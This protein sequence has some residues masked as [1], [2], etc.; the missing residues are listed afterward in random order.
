MKTQTIETTVFS[1]KSNANYITQVMSNNV[2]FSL[3]KASFIVD[4]L[5]ESG[6][7]LGNAIDIAVKVNRSNTYRATGIERAIK[8]EKLGF[9]LIDMEMIAGKIVYSYIQPNITQELAVRLIASC[10]A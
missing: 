2:D 3:P 8:L 1:T 10:K 9:I 5:M 4:A 7:Q 6:Y